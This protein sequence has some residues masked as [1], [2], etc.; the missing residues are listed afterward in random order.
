[1]TKELTKAKGITL[2]TGAIITWFAVVFQFYLIIINRVASIPET[3]IRF[4]SFYTVLTNI[5]V[6]VYFTTVL[7]KPISRF[8][9]FFSLPSVA[10]AIALYILIVGLIYNVILRFLWQ[11]QGLQLV[12]DELLHTVVPLFFIFYWL[13]FV[14]KS[15]LKWKNIFSWLTYPMVYL[16][17]IF[18]RGAFSGYY[19]Y[20]FIKVNDIGWNKALLNSVALFF[21]FLIGSILFVAVAKI[22]SRGQNGH[23]KK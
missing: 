21:V 3:I 1:M 12:V 2:A 19:P 6:A 5:L 17:F 8:G 7:V 4:F 23:S 11:P 18:L 9:R 14:R 22:M 16:I 15:E 10:T 13:I 20:P